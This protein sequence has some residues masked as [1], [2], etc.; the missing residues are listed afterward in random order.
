MSAQAIDD[1]Y[2][3]VQ[4]AQNDIDV[5]AGE[6]LWDAFAILLSNLEVDPAAPAIA[7]QAREMVGIAEQVLS[8]K[9]MLLL[10]L[11]MKPNLLQ[12]GDN[13]KSTLLK[14]LTAGELCAGYYF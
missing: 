12:F 1:L 3:R 10:C 7:K 11:S 4:A 14:L 9:E 6:I 2:V 5:D 13:A 8:S